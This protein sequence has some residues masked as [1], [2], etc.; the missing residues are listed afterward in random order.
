MSNNSYSKTISNNTNISNTFHIQLSF[1]ILSFVFILFSILSSNI[2]IVSSLLQLIA[3]IFII[4]VIFIYTKYIFNLIQLHPDL[5]YNTNK[6]HVKNH[7]YLNFLL[8][9]ILLCSVFYFL[10]HLISYK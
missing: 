1:I 6:K 3:S 9:I 10:F 5:F 4:I 8:Y 2:K 7:L